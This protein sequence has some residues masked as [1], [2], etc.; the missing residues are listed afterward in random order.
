MSDSFDDLMSPIIE[1]MKNQREERRFQA[2][3]AAMTGI[4]GMAWHPAAGYAP[5]TTLNEDVIPHAVR[6]GDALLAELNKKKEEQNE[7]LN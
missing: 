7:K 1:P 6:L 4:L 3:C 2:A 5:P